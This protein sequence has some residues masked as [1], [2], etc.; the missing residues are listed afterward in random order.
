MV[1]SEPCDTAIKALIRRLSLRDLMPEDERNALRSA[2]VRSRNFAAGDDLVVENSKPSVSMLVA[3]GMV[4]RYNIIEDG[5]RQITAFHMLG[6]FVD[7]HGFLLSRL[8]HSISALTEVTV[9]EFPHEA[10]EHIT[11]QYPHLTRMMWLSTLLDAAIHRQWLVVMG[12]TSAMSR[13]AHLLCEQFVRASLV[14]LAAQ[15]SFPFP[16]TQAQLA[17]ALGIS[18]VHVNRTLQELRARAVLEWH[19]GTVSI[20]DWPGLQSIGR[21][22]EA[23]LDIEHRRR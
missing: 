8:D 3:S 16:I 11:E 15:D 21:F 22:D 14:G 12:R 9:V 1:I 2:A 7:L 13:L 20:L 19:G 23:F 10:L 18:P 5:G 4:A 6:D 17:D